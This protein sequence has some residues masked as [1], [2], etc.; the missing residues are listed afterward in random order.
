MKYYFI[1][2][3]FSIQKLRIQIQKVFVTRNDKYNNPKKI[4]FSKKSEKDHKSTH[5]CSEK[6][7]IKWY[8]MILVYYIKKLLYSTKKRHFIIDCF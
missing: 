5:N 8:K 1:L 4:I 2:K 7:Y 3:I 6:F